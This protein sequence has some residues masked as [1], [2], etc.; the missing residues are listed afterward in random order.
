MAR[1][2]VLLTAL[3]ALAACDAQGDTAV[4]LAPRPQEAMSPGAFRASLT[5]FGQTS[6]ADVSGVPQGYTEVDPLNAAGLWLA[7]TQG[8]ETRA[9]AIYYGPGGSNYGPCDDGTGGVF[10]L[11]A[12]STYLADGWPVAAGAPVTADGR[13]RAYGD[14]MLW[15][16]LCSVP[17]DPSRLQDRPLDGLRVNVAVFRYDDEPSVIYVRYELRNG[18]AEAITDAYAG[19]WSDPDWYE[20]TE[21]LSGFDRDRALS[22]VYLS[23]RYDTRVENRGERRTP[24]ERGRVTGVAV[25]QAPTGAPLAGHRELRKNTPGPTSDVISA[26]SG[27]TYESYRYALRGL[28]NDGSD[29]VDPS[30]AVSQFAFTGDPVSGTGWLDGGDGDGPPRGRELRA[31]TSAG[32]FALAPGESAA[33]TVVW[34]VASGDG[35]AG[36]LDA[37]RQHVDGARAAPS[38]WRF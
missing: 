22:Y 31:L 5:A 25:L 34:A 10:A 17:A 2:P 26:A 16:S 8:G 29:V 12:D 28:G 38:R 36:G 33:F 20:A 15:T 18:G 3:V 13:P 6:T 23:E 32:P 14:E 19:Q 21:N 1:L 30:G 24:L 4:P 37:L 7:G 11:S 35:L 9:N 27:G